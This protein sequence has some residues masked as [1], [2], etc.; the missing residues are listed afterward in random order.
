LSEPFWEATKSQRL[1]F[2]RCQDCDAAVW[3]PRRR[4]PA[5][6]SDNLRWTDSS[7]SGSVYTF[8][9]MRRPGNPMMADEV[10][11]VVAIVEL[12]EGY[13]MLTNITGCPPESVAC[14]RRVQVAWEVELSDGRRLPTFHLAG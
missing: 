1:L 5:C 3:Y 10:P 4:C 7:G 12:D 8:N 6:I 13:R 11:Y 9:V 14:G 2:Q